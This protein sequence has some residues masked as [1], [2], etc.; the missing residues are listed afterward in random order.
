MWTIRNRSRSAAVIV[1]SRSALGLPPCA[2]PLAAAPEQ[3]LLSSPLRPSLRPRRPHALIVTTHA[4]PVN[5]WALVIAIHIYELS[6]DEYRSE[7]IRVRTLVLKKDTP[8]VSRPADSALIARPSRQS[9]AMHHGP[10]ALRRTSICAVSAWS[11]SWAMRN[12]ACLLRILVAPDPPEQPTTDH[13][14]QRKQLGHGPGDRM[15]CP[16][17]GPPSGKADPDGPLTVHRPAGMLPSG[18]FFLFD[19]LRRQARRAMGAQLPPI[20]RGA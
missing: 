18:C 14:D 2:A 1:A 5:D 16:V 20:S 12:D 9:Q 13:H 15:D 7:M 10:A 17:T 3:L 19:L 11:C 8:A 4:W 6:I